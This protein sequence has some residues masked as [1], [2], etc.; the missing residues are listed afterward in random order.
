MAA[1]AARNRAG[2]AACRAARMYEALLTDCD[3]LDG[4]VRVCERLQ[5]EA[6]AAKGAEKQAQ[7]ATQEMGAKLKEALANTAD[8]EHQLREALTR[9]AAVKAENETLLV[10]LTQQ[11]Q[12]QAEQMDAE[13]ERSEQRRVE[14]SEAPAQ[15]VESEA[16]APGWLSRSIHSIDAWHSTGVGPAQQSSIGSASDGDVALAGPGIARAQLS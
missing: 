5:M 6:L 16:A 7:E 13:V 15:A 1:L 9:E 12:M 8:L 11:L 10:R 3:V 4:Q 2:L 14:V